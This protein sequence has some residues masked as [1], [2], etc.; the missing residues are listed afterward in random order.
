MLVPD[1]AIGTEQTRKYVLTVSAD[2]V[3]LI[4]YVTLGQSFNNLRVIKSGLQADDLVIVNGLMRA[5]A[6]QKVTPQKQTP[7]APIPGSPQAKA[8]PNASQPKTE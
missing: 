3:A 5:R 6:N 8:D 4:K 7:A 2:N 1:A